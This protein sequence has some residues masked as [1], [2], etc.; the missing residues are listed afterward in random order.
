VTGT[1]TITDDDRLPTALT[2]KFFATKTKVGAKGLL[3]SATADAKV[4]VTLAKKKNG[5]WVQVGSPRTVTVT[6]LGD[7]DHDG[8]PDAQYKASFKRPRRGTYK[9]TVTFAGNTTLA[10][11]AKTATFK[12]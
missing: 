6:K 12:L 3:E 9:V 7:R 10:P 1:G 4:T 8:K 5:A 11:S 2:L